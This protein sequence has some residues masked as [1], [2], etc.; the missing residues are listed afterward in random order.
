M[1]PSG[2]SSTCPGPPIF[3][4][5]GT[6]ELDADTQQEVSAAIARACRGGTAL[7]IAHRVSTV[8]DADR[9]VVMDAGQVV[10]EGP[11]AQLAGHPGPFTLLTER[12]ASE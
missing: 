7:I 9:I 10:Q 8:S 4:D 2:T 11:L 3:F 12:E 1:W 6:S 5:E